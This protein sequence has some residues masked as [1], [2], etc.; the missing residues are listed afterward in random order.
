[1]ATKRATGCLLHVG[2]LPPPGVAGRILMLASPWNAARAALLTGVVV[3]VG[4]G[5]S[6]GPP[7]GDLGESCC[8]GRRCDTGTCNGG[9]SGVCAACGEPGQ[10][11]CDLGVCGGGGC[12]VND[13][14]T[15]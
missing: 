2:T 5:D 13:I 11:C 10:A 3:C 1:M 4:C 14:C 7:C 9:G 15:G 12:C 6:S 8:E